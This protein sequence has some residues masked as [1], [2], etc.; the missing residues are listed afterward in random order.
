LPCFHY[1]DVA[2][3]NISS[4]YLFRINSHDDN[5]GVEYTRFNVDIYGRT[6]IGSDLGMWDYCGSQYMLYVQGGIRTEKVHVDDVTN[7]CDY[8]FEDDYELMPLSDLEKYLSENKH[9]PNVPSE[10]EVKENG[11]DV[12]EMDAALLRKIEELTLYVIEL[13]KENEALKTEVE[14]QK[15]EKQQLSKE[16]EE[17]LGV[18]EKQ[19]E[20][21]ASQSSK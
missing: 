17:R 10:Q 6:T 1:P 5:D 4:D 7:W 13:K 2:N 14:E 12:V 21:L 9:L 8:V 16:L 3:T 11:F 19:L 20:Q 18:I 15:S